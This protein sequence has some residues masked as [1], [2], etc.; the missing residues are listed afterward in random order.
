MKREPFGAGPLSTGEGLFRRLLESAPDAMVIVD[1]KG[2]IVL[3]NAQM[4]KLFGYDRE[5]LVG[6]PIEIL[7]P[8]RLSE[9]HRQHR[10]GYLAHPA[11]RP[12]GADLELRGRRSDGTEFPVDISL[13]PLETE[14]GL[15][16]AASIREVTDRRRVEE[17]LR[18]SETLFR[19]LLEAAPDA[20]VIVDA[21]ARIA[22]VNGQTEK[23]FGYSRGELVGQ[24]IE[25][26]LP[27]RFRDGH[28][29]HRDGY[30]AA[31]T[32]RPMGVDLELLGRRKDGIEVPVNISL[33]PY[34]TA[35]GTLVLSAIRDVTENKRVESE[36]RRLAEEAA[37][38]NAAKSEFLSRMSHELRTPLNAIIG[39]AQLLELDRLEPA[40]DEG[41]KHILR[42]GRHLLSLINEI[43]DVSQIESGA[44]ALS[45]EPVS[46]NGV[47]DE[48]LDLIAPLA[49]ERPVTIRVSGHGEHPAFVFADQQRLLQ[50][51]LNLLGNAVKYNEPGG[52]VEISWTG[53]ARE[54]SIAVRDGGAG[55]AAEDLE[56]IFSPFERLSA[57]A[58]ATE[59]TGLGL[60]VAQSLVV[61][62][63]GTIEV[64]STPGVGST[65]TVR[66]RAAAA[67]G[68]PGDAPAADRSGVDALSARRTVLHIDDNLTGQRVVER[69][70]RRL[71][72]ITI[73]S[74]SYGHYGLEL[75]RRERPDVI[76]L[77]LHL[78]DLPGEEVMRRLQDDAATRD[79]P[80]VIVSADASRET[81]RRLTAAGAS[82]LVSKPIDADVLLAVLDELTS[83]RP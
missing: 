57:G 38:A 23:L 45:L 43:L 67:N 50:V 6:S 11:R 75:A 30:L 34:E 68:M 74:S 4:E 21:D 80:V 7:I 81:A 82:T 59:G 83:V 52:T 55:I 20:I 42:A 19:G 58:T 70:V 44:F 61:A 69:L 12:M 1:G 73:V 13:S 22:L 49:A 53:D 25:S 79:I 51:L 78:P 15:L 3:V 10:S 71:P 16:V 5:E 63:E 35:Q 18:R 27:D 54:V 31:P 2:R 33:S 8:E 26:L 9:T 48:A 62:M 40:Q 47:V 77:D 46:V 60:A 32:A 29:A 65:F 56:H 36:I 41:V 37:R 64:Q 14:E 72:G 17:E 76:L 39:F 66:L 24:P 28:R